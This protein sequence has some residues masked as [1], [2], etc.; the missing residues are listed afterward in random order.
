MKKNIQSAFTLIELL[1]VISIIA[2]LVGLSFFG[3]QGA[4]ESSRDA[5]RKADL[6]SLRSGLE[7][8]KSD[9]NVYP[10]SLGSSLNGDDSSTGCDSDNVYI[11]DIPE[12]PV[13]GKAYVYS[14]SG[15]LTYEICTSLEQGTGTVTCGGSSSCGTATC[16]YKVTNP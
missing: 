3:L 4:R 2:I 11:A 9:C 10:D 7:I 16:N 5:K 6:E 13:P 8:F 1:V 14:S 15:G 12:D